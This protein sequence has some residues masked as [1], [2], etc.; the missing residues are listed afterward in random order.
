MATVLQRLRLA[1]QLLL[2]NVMYVHD[3]LG[4]FKVSLD[5][6]TAGCSA[7]VRSEGL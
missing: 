3:E 6:Q 5:T 7:L 4:R 2:R 1:A